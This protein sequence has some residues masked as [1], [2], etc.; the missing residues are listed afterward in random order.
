MGCQKAE[1]R[2]HEGGAQ[3]GACH[4]DPDDGLRIFTAEV[5]RGGVNDGGVDWRAAKT[6][7][8]QTCQSREIG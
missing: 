5:V 4:L 3:I 8:D 7:D 2:G 6:H 1:H